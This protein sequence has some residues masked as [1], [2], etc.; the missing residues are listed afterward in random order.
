MQATP[1]SRP[2]HYVSQRQLLNRVILLRDPVFAASRSPSHRP[3]AFSRVRTSSRYRS[4][5]RVRSESGA[6][7]LCASGKARSNFYIGI[8]QVI[9]SQVKTGPHKDATIFGRFGFLLPRLPCNYLILLVPRGG[10][11]PPCGYLRWILS[12]SAT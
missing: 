5:G 2:V 1:R 11:E 7:R 6:F 10:L 3:L 9:K 8:V 12:S 4:S